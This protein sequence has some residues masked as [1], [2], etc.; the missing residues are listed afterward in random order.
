MNIKKV[1][2]CQAERESRYVVVDTLCLSKSKIVM[3]IVEEQSRSKN[4]GVRE[5]ECML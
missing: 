4:Y 5:R 1:V 2:F 3:L